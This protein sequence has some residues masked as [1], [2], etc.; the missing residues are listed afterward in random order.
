MDSKS[1]TILV[2]Y[3]AVFASALLLTLSGCGSELPQAQADAVS[4]LEA[5]GAK[6]AIRDSKVTYVD[7]YT[8]RDV[9]GAIIHVE[10]LPDVEKLNF[11]GTKMG[12]DELAHL[13]KLSQ[14]KELGLTGTD[15]TDKGLAHLTGLSKLERLTLNNCDIS[16]AGLVHLQ[17]LKG[18]KQLHLNETKVSD[19]GLEHLT[20]LEKLEAL[21]VYDTAVTSSGAAAF[22]EKRPETTV[23]TSEGESG[24]NDESDGE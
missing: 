1:T 12:D 10:A 23:V 20:G 8:V 7:Y 17:N 24:A 21:L 11:S 14:L 19:A 22:R 18:L 15:I 5:A 4:K 2:F 16:D 9:P 3:T 6:I 13:A